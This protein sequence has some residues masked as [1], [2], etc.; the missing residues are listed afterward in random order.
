MAHVAV[1]GEGKGEGVVLVTVEGEGVEHV[2]VEGE[3]VVLDGA[4]TTSSVSVQPP[5]C[6][7]DLEKNKYFQNQNSSQNICIKVEAYIT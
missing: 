1:E 7:S 6:F 2:A 5:N 4:F 3:G